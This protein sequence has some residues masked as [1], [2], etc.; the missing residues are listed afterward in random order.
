MKILVILNQQPIIPPFMMT[1]LICAKGLYQDIYYINTCDP[2]NKDDSNCGQGVHFRYPKRWHS[3]KALIKAGVSFFSSPVFKDFFLCIKERGV[4]VRSIRH[5]LVEQYVHQRLYPLARKV[6]QS[7]NATEEITILSTWFDA[8]SFTA[9][10]LKRK[11]PNVKAVSLAHSYEILPIRNPYVRYMH[12]R[13]KF[14][15]LDGVY[16]ISYKIRDMFFKGVDNLEM[17]LK[18]KAFVAYLGS[19]KNTSSINVPDPDSFNICSCS[20]MIPLKRIELILEVLRDWDQCH[21]KWTHIGDGPL[22]ADITE[23]ARKICRDNPMVK[24]DLVGRV[25]N[26]NVKLFYATHPIDLF[27]NLSE[28]EG[29]PISIMEAISYGIPVLATDVGGTSEIVTSG[30]G[31][32]LDAHISLV[33]VRQALLD[34]CGRSPENK[35]KLRSSA[36]EYWRSNFDANTNLKLLFEKINNISPNYE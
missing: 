33:E 30:T 29:L 24:I 1:A 22:F 28:I 27:V 32:L 4:S 35:M 2:S 13:Y 5:F 21:I 15:L 8:C 23:K 20:R 6:I 26:E 11:Y 10:K 17:D 3:Q 18:K 9:S 31:Y 34:Y 14:S 16:F 12:N 25:T 7:N 36:Y 19:I